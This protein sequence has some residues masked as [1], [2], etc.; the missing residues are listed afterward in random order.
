[1]KTQKITKVLIALD[2]DPTAQKVAETGFRFAKSL[3]AEITLLHVILDPL[4]YSSAD[5]SPIMGFTG[6]AD[7]GPMET[8]SVDELKNAAR[9]YLDKAKH[10]LGDD[11]TKTLIREGDIA[12]SILEAS[13]AIHADMIVIGSFSR[14]LL[15]KIFMGSVTEKVMQLTK[16]PLLIIPTG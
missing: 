6:Y 2:Y 3:D 11:A 4:K 1:M 13:K 5:Y 15:D 12:E 14:K 16:V 7:I 9:K 8:D 10:H